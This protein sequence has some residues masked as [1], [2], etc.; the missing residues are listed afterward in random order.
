RTHGKT[1]RFGLVA[2][3]IINRAVYARKII[4]RSFPANNTHFRMNHRT[5]QGFRKY[6]LR[7]GTETLGWGLQP[8]STEGT[9]THLLHKAIEYE[10]DYSRLTVSAYP[11]DLLITL[12]GA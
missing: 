1:A 4:L 7:N 8:I 9:A 11:R 12:T 3:T 10:L 6:R 5:H 2:R